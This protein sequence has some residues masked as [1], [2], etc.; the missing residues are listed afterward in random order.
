MDGGAALLG[1]HFTQ[2][3]EIALESRASW[4]MKA[5]PPMW[6]AGSWNAAPMRNEETQKQTEPSAEPTRSM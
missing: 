4:L 1:P 2:G 5:F 6:R 3:V